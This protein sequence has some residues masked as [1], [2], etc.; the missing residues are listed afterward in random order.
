MSNFVN[1]YL[2][3]PS[4]LLYQPKV[5]LTDE[6]PEEQSFLSRNKQYKNN[7]KQK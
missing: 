4:L 3:S 5:E 7:I 1:T 2:N 6:R